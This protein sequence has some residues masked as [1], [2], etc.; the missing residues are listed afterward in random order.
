MSDHMNYDAD[1]LSGV[2]AFGAAHSLR[3]NEDD[4]IIIAR[5]LDYVKTQTYDRKLPPLRGLELFPVSNDTPAWAETIVYRAY[6]MVGVAKIIANYAD[7]LPRADVKG[8]EK[9]V[10]VRTIGD[11]YGYNVQELTVSAAMGTNLPSRKATAARQAIEVKINQIA[12]VGDPLYGLQG[13]ATHPNIGTTTGITGDWNGA[14]TAEQIVADVNILYQ[15]VRIQSK[16]V[17]TPNRFVLPMTAL[18]AAQRKTVAGS[19]GKSA[20]TVIREQ[21]PNLQLVDM[22]ELEAGGVTTDSLALMGEFNEM[23]ASFEMV[24]DFTQL[25]AQARNLELVVPCY[26]RAGGVSVHY[27]LAFTKATDI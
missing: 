13:G 27:P 14:A 23:N 2:V 7:D 5:A 8:T 20:Y 6:D 12:M 16:G 26:A 22:I 10:P 4:S 18:A 25:P 1:D 21:F 11:S 15:A 3:F 17:H 9:T 24:M 19:G